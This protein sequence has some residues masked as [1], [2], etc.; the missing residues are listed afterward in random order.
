[1]KE[2]LWLEGSGVTFLLPYMEATLH[3]TW[4][5]QSCLVVLK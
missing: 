3:N 1:M 4:F 2:D 5:D